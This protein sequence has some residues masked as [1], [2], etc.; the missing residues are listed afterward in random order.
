MLQ[1]AMSTIKAWNSHP[2]METATLMG[3]TPAATIMLAMQP[4]RMGA[5]MSRQVLLVFTF[6]HF[7]K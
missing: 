2:T 4:P 3:A 5:G 1:E 6:G 7:R